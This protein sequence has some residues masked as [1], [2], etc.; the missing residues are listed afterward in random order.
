MNSQNTPWAT[1]QDLKNRWPSLP[2]EHHALAVILLADAT[3]YLLDI[4]PASSTAPESTRRRIVCSIVKRSLEAAAL[5]GAGFESVQIG[6][7]PFQDTY[8]PLNPHGDFYLTM[9]EKKALGVGR[10]KA[11][12]FDMLGDA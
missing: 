11:A 5:P 9:Q 10:Q 7:G 8:K 1:L 12:S 2:E 3:Q 6:T 4:A